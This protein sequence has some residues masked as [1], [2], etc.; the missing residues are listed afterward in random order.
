MAQVNLSVILEKRAAVALADRDP[1]S[2]KIRSKFKSNC[3]K[4]GIKVHIL[5]RYALE[6]YFTVDA[7]RGVFRGQIPGDFIHRF[8]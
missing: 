4:L 5:K 1:G 7:L 8:R 3:D 2:A 6:N